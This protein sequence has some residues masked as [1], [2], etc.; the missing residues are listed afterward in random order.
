MIE[1]N[2]S[3]FKGGLPDY[4]IR[5]TTFRQM[6]IFEAIVRLGSFTRA[7]EELFL[8]QPT[9]SSQV[10]KLTNVMG[11]PLLDQ[12]GRS[13]KPT[14]AGSD[15]YQAVRNIFDCLSD[16][17]TR[18]AGLKGLQRGRLRLAVITTAKYF[19]P[20]ILGDFCREHPGI[21]VT[22]KV[23]N[24]DRILERIQNNEDDL[25]I[26]GQLPEKMQHLEAHHFAPNPLVVLAPKGHPLC[27]ESNI[28]IERLAREPFIVREVGSGIRDTT[29]KVFAEK[30]LVPN[31]RMELGSNE[32]IKHSV[33]AGLGLTISSLHTLTLEGAKGP[34]A[35]LDVVGFPIERIWY[36]VHPKDK[37]LSLIAK[38]FFEFAMAGE[39][40]IRARMQTLLGDFSQQQKSIKAKR[41][42]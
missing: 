36:V 1:K 14:Q 13:I 10:K 31:V 15:L 29:M 5:H 25:Y 32:A 35:M 37:E 28:S 20:E 12:A 9:V 17:D 11:L 34:I 19:T 26:L 2:D 4:L 16:L 7:A 6:Q 30:G 38:T 22:L 33:V 23:A 18:I 27:E 41:R 3:R 39:P 21:D 24:R 42:A 40:V 8:T